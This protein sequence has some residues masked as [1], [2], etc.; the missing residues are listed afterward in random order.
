MAPRRCRFHRASRE[1]TKAAFDHTT[2][3]DTPSVTYNHSVVQE[4]LKLDPHKKAPSWA[5]LSLPR[6]ILKAYDM[7]RGAAGLVTR[8]H[9]LCMGLGVLIARILRANERPLKRVRRHLHRSDDVLVK[10]IARPRPMDGF[11]AAFKA[12]TSN[13]GGGRRQ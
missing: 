7:N 5:R 13:L 12:P 2:R 11:R 10:G 1:P 9:L 3:H 6:Q 4:A 8:D